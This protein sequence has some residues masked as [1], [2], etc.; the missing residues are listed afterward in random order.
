MTHPVGF[1]RIIVFKADGCRLLRTPSFFSVVNN[2]LVFQDL[3]CRGYDP[4][5]DAERVANYGRQVT[6]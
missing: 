4:L 1:S 6:S 5:F 2:Y 3:V